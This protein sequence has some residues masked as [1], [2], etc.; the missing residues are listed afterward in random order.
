M[1]KAAEDRGLRVAAAHREGDTQLTKT[2]Y[3]IGS[4]KYMAPEQILGKKVDERRMSTPSAH[5]VRDRHGVPPYS[6]GDHMSVMYQHVQGKARIAQEINPNLPP[7]LSD[8]VMKS[9]RWTRRSA[10]RAWTSSDWCWRSSSS[11]R[12]KSPAPRMGSV[13]GH[14]LRFRRQ[15]A[16]LLPGALGAL[17]PLGRGDHSVAGLRHAWA[18]LACVTSNF[19][20]QA[21]DS[22]ARRA[23]QRATQEHRGETF[24]A[25]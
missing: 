10:T 1:T 15:K 18:K 24:G 17:R 21:V 19:R 13:F 11:P 20:P 5:A 9:W 23:K 8:V 14:Q 12:E 25:Y 4:P 2:G 7:G 22:P 16:R 6:R 3:V